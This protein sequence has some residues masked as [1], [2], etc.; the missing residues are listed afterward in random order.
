M[1]KLIEAGRKLSVVDDKCLELTRSKQWRKLAPIL[2]GHDAL[3]SGTMAAPAVPVAKM[4]VRPPEFDAEGRYQVRYMT[5]PFN[6][7]GQ[8]PVLSVPSGFT[9]EGLP[10]GLSICGRRFEEA[11]ILHIGA[12]L[13]RVRPWS[14]RR[15]VV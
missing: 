10:T 8:C 1:V 13:E 14:E 6:L 3:L 2:A 15:S 11:T 9:P 12:A 7:V 5:E 4:H